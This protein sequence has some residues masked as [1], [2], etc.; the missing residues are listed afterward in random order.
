[1][2]KNNNRNLVLA[3]YI[4]LVVTLRVVAPLLGNFASVANFTVLG[5]VALFG[6]A[7]F[8]NNAFAFGFPLVTLFIS[9]ILLSIVF[10][11]TGSILYGGWYWTYIAFI[12]MVIAG[13]ILLK[14]VTIASFL[15]GTLAVVFIHWIL[16]DFG[17]WLGSSV[18]PQTVA[19]FWQCLVAAIPFELR[20]LYGTA[21]YGGVMFGSFEY[22]K[23]KFPSLRLQPES[24]K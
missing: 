9:D 1:M 4:L 13:K 24:I 7:Y 15:S 5:A 3:V 12:L 20:F 2:T 6:A 16:T 19:G 22:F 11:K 23:A 21:I 8:K 10:Y 17:V 18:Y 14:K